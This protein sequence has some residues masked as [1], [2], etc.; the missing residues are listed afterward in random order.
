MP[1]E[2]TAVIERDPSGGYWAYCLEV[3]S[4]YGQGATIEECRADLA[5]A[6]KFVLEVQ[7]E[8]SLKQA[9]SDAVREIVIVG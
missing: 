3:P 9:S 1:N 8:E 6:I 7:R 5:E 4:A 2:F